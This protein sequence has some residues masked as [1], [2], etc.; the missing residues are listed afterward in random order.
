[1]VFPLL[2]FINQIFHLH[3]SSSETSFIMDNRDGYPEN[4]EPCKAVQARRSLYGFSSKFSSGI[5]P[6]KIEF[7]KLGKS[8][9]PDTLQMLRWVRL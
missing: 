8:Q 5:F 3:P 2:W 1:M 4:P 9:L 6:K 7:K